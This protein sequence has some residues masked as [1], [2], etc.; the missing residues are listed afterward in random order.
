MFARVTTVQ[1]SPGRVDEA[2]KRWEDVSVRLIQQ[3]PGL[4]QAL[5]L[6]DPGSGKMLAISLWE[7]EAERT[8]YEQSGVFQQML[9]QY[10]DLINGQ[11]ATERYEVRVRI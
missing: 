11:P 8:T 9:G 10:A 3:Q 5:L 1:A 6:V 7:T 2:A 4:N